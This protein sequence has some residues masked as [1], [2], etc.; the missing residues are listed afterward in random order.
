MM[1]T[2]NGSAPEVS[3]SSSDRDGRPVPCTEV[4][5]DV[6]ARLQIGA[7]AIV[8]AATSAISA[9][10]NGMPRPSRVS[11]SRAAST[12]SRYRRLS[13]SSEKPH[14]DM[15]SRRSILQDWPKHR[16]GGDRAR[17]WQGHPRAY[18]C[19]PRHRAARALLGSDGAPSRRNLTGEFDAQRSERSDG[20][21]RFWTHGLRARFAA[22]RAG[23]RFSH[24]CCQ[25][26]GR[27]DRFR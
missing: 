3:T 15:L 25:W 7:T 19:G 13:T 10:C 21:E 23:E 11:A 4:P 2:T 1:S 26:V 16:L 12:C 14:G 8:D 17:S 20:V 6:T 9:R 24:C 27:V 22:L 18:L 5:F